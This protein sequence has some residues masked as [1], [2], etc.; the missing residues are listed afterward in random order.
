MPSNEVNMKVNGEPIKC[1]AKGPLLGQILENIS[2]STPK[3]K[4]KDTVNLYGQMVD[5]T[6][7]SGSMA[8]NTAKELT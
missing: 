4:R 1:M 3:T 5:V 6:E 8:S 2:E 7:A